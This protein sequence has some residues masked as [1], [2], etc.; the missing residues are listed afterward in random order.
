MLTNGELIL[1]AAG[2]GV[3]GTVCGTLVSGWI[4]V[5]IGQ[6]AARRAGDLQGSQQMHQ[7]MLESHQQQHERELEA[8]R[9]RDDRRAAL[10]QDTLEAMQLLMRDQSRR[11]LDYPEPTEEENEASG[12]RQA[13]LSS[14]LTLFGSPEVSKLFEQWS[15][16]F[17]EGWFRPTPTGHRERLANAGCLGGADARGTGSAQHPPRPCTLTVSAACTPSAAPP[18]HGS[19]R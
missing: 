9:R 5:L 6:Q 8:N 16:V 2:I 18:L 1:G 14:R 4:A 13:N 3:L 7:M 15:S 12:L 19:S 11:A 17:G 10:Y